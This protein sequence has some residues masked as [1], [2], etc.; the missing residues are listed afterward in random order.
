MTAAPHTAA[1]Q[2]VAMYNTE[3][4]DS[5]RS[6]YTSYDASTK[7]PTPSLEP[8]Q[9]VGTSFTQVRPKKCFAPFRAYP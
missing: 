1:T 3:S 9:P 6:N 2:G 8:E 7:P 5:Y 4:Y